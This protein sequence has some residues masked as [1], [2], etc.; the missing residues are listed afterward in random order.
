MTGKEE[1]IL[2]LLDYL[3]NMRLQAGARALAHTTFCDECSS[4][5]T[6]AC[7]HDAHTAAYQAQQDALRLHSG[8]HR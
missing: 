8:A 6:I 4:V 1:M 7:R 2:H 3:R 5:C